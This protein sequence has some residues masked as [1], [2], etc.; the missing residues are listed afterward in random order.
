[1][2]PFTGLSLVLVSALYGSLT[3]YMAQNCNIWLIMIVVVHAGWSPR[4]RAESSRLDDGG[5]GD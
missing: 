5:L 1:M 4:G 3:H 2:E